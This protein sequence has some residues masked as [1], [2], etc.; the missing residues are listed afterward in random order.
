MDAARCASSAS[1]TAVCCGPLRANDVVRSVS[2]AA[3]SIQ[4][5]RTAGK[6]GR[7]GADVGTRGWVSAAACNMAQLAGEVPQTHG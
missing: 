7:P 3:K 4:A 5:E 1:G 2:I 6:A